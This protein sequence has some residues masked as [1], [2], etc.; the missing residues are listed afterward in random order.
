MYHKRTRP[1]EGAGRDV[2]KEETTPTVE[3][4]SATPQTPSTTTS[5]RTPVDPRDVLVARLQA[6][7]ALVQSGDLHV[8][9]IA[10]LLGEAADMLDRDPYAG[11]SQPS[12]R[13]AARLMQSMRSGSSPHK[14]KVRPWRRAP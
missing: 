14:S 1:A 8:D 9:A 2:E 10:E 5:S 12:Q 13:P 3:S 6:R 11:L 4:S 7:V